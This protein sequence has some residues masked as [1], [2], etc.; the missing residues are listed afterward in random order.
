MVV[1]LSQNMVTLIS[2]RLRSLRSSIN[3]LQYFVASI[4]IQF[5]GSHIEVSA[6][7]CFLELKQIAEFL[8]R[9]RLL[10]LICHI[11]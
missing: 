4:S 5:L 7:W 10:E 3:L 9:N 1:L 2:G 6:N 11:S 8:S